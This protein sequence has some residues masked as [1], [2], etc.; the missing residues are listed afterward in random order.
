MVD[1]ADFLDNLCKQLQ[2]IKGQIKHH[3]D[4]HH[5]QISMDAVNMLEFQSDVIRIEMTEKYQRYHYLKNKLGDYIKSAQSNQVVEPES[6][7][8]PDENCD[9][10][11]DV[12]ITDMEMATI[13]ANHTK[14]ILKSHEYFII[15][16]ISEYIKQNGIINKVKIMYNVDS[17]HA[18]ATKFE[19]L[20]YIFEV[21][22]IQEWQKLELETKYKQWVFHNHV[23]KHYKIK[24]NDEYKSKLATTE[25]F[26]QLSLDTNVLNYHYQKYYDYYSEGQEANY[27]SRWTDSAIKDPSSKNFWDILF[28][29]IPI[30]IA[31]KY[32]GLL[33]GLYIIRIQAFS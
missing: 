32:H 21:N 25:P 1:I 2:L 6:N 3:N 23:W 5:D 7:H 29:D 13:D 17:H 9:I 14:S 31:F 20:K 12:Y 28:L 16:T 33:G 27:T 11:Q 19:L 15:N 8:E 10:K 24:W 22:R 18:E 26:W 4:M 30:K